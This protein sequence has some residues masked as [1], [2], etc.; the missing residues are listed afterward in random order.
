M[1]EV[2]GH[3]A[4]TH[5]GCGGVHYQLQ[6]DRMHHLLNITQSLSL[7]HNYLTDYYIDK[8]SNLKCIHCNMLTYNI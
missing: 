4:G 5:H 6:F 7:Q 2:L 8:I 1:L 3:H